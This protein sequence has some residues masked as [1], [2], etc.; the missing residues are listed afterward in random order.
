MALA[1]AIMSFWKSEMAFT[2]SVNSRAS[3]RRERVRAC[4]Y[5]VDWDSESSFAMSA[6]CCLVEFL[7]ACCLNVAELISFSR[8]EICGV[9]SP[10]PQI[11]QREKEIISAT[12]KQHANKNS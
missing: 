1:A 2:S 12:F 5:K 3:K 11:S 4:A 6:A 10:P 7:F 8:C 9:C